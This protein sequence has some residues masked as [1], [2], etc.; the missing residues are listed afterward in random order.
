MAGDCFCTVTHFGLWLC[1]MRAGKC[2]YW[3][4]L[5]CM[6]WDKANLYWVGGLNFEVSWVGIALVVMTALIIFGGIKR[7]AKVAE[8]IVPF[9]AL[10]YII[11]FVHRHHQLPMLPGI[12]NLF[13]LKHSV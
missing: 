3:G 4:N 11:G 2:D 8:G 5:T 13:S 7:I 6:G 9:M 1:L 12:L 10:L